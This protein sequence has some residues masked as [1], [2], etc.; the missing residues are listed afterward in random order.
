MSAFKV[1]F[2]LKQHTPIIHFQS[3]QA[4]ATLRATELKPKLDRFL[5]AHV[6]E[7]PFK[8]NANGEKS[9]D[10]KVNITA[11]SITRG[12]IDERD[13]LFFGNMKPKE[14]SDEEFER[15]KKYFIKNELIK[16]EFLSFNPTVQ[17]A[18]E[19]H[20]ESFLAQTNF[21]TRQ[22]K[23]F[24]CFYLDKPF[25]SSLI[26]FKVYSFNTQNWKNDIKL[27][28]AFL[29]QGINY[30]LGRDKPSRFYCK[31]AIF[32]Y[33]M[34]Q[35]WTW[36]KKAIKQ[37]FFP[38]DL[39]AQQQKHDANSPVNAVGQSAY[40]LRD[41]FGLSSDQSWMSYKV[42]IKKEHKD[43]DRFKS[44]LN[45]KIIGNQVYFWADKSVETMLDQTFKISTRGNRP[46]EL[47]TP[48]RFSFD[49]FFEHVKSIDLQQHIESK[50][51]KERE[52][53]DL[54]RI[55]NGIKASK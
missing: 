15:K 27:L 34:K 21:G 17:K 49:E 23:G 33:A 1:A 40:L 50:F 52:F 36:D 3:N 45:F 48:E 39:K 8:K 51:H 9:L 14:M 46:L 24:G 12:D 16:I 13:P 10:Y 11:S 53:S 38:N 30:P 47:K 32:T 2:T 18:I 22:S 7:L 5:V 25:N 4:G 29:R 42:R 54:N 41:L 44:P 19:V 20:F 28:Y 35:N 6:K 43:I 37:H 31:P 26:P 55:L